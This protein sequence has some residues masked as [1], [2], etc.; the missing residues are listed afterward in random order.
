MGSIVYG[1][2]QCGYEKKEMCLGGGML[3]FQTV[4]KF[5]YYCETCKEVKVHNAFI[6]PTICGCGQLMVRYDDPTLSKQT[7]EK[8]YKVFDWNMNYEILVLTDN[9]YLCPKC[10][11]YT[12]EWN[13]GGCWD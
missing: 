5:P 4:A 8:P 1:A 6:K 3:D 12:L 7:S 10:K 9:G 13:D 2:C 11:E